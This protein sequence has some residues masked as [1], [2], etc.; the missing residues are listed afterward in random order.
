MYFKPLFLYFCYHVTPDYLIYAMISICVCSCLFWIWTCSC[1][2]SFCDFFGCCC[3]CCCCCCYYWISVVGLLVV[4]ALRTCTVR[5]VGCRGHPANMIHHKVWVSQRQLVHPLGDLERAERAELWE[6]LSQQS[7]KSWQPLR[8]KS[9]W[10]LWALWLSRP[11]NSV[12]ELKRWKKP[13]G[14]A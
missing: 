11:A 12:E 9:W 1:S 6:P 8:R 14:V 10:Q 5:A 2:L 3:C 4:T 7:R 13:L